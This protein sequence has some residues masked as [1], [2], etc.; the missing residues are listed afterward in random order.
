MV[1]PLISSAFLED[2]ERD[3]MPNDAKLGL[4]VGLGVV[5]ATSVV[6]FRKDVAAAP[7]VTLPRA[8]SV[9]PASEISAA[10]A[11][12]TEGQPTSREKE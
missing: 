3:K 4:V 9:S 8:A 6:F 7:Q 5:I 11:H 1:A 2:R 12:E 10:S